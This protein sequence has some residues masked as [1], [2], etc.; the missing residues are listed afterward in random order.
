MLCSI[1]TRYRSPE[2]SKGV[3]VSI[4]IPC[5]FIEGITV[6]DVLYRSG[7]GYRRE[8]LACRGTVGA[9]L[10]GNRRVG[11]ARRPL[12]APRLLRRRRR[13]GFLAAPLRRTH[14]TARLSRLGRVL[15]S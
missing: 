6:A 11:S 1:L 2:W 14:R 8:R 13:R 5:N 3:V 4:K 15:P 12:P 7:I 10:D 9:G